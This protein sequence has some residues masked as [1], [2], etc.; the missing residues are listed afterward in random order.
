MGCGSGGG[1]TGAYGGVVHVMA[2]EL[3][4]ERGEGTYL[5]DAAEGIRAEVRER[6]L[7]AVQPKPATG[8]DVR[9]MAF[10]L[11]FL[12]LFI[13]VVGAPVWVHLAG[14]DAALAGASADD[15]D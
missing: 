10:F 7:K 5:V 9:F 14:Y 8:V 11:L 3:A 1:G 13:A 2:R 12:F 6:G 4:R 15:D